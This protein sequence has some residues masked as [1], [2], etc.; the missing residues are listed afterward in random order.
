M[1]R[2]ARWLLALAVCWLLVRSGALAQQGATAEKPQELKSA[3]KSWKLVRN[4]VYAQRPSGELKADLFLQHAAG[5]HP[6][7]VVIHGGAW[8][9]GVKEQLHFVARRLADAG[10]VAMCIQ[11]RL[12][13]KHKFPAQVEDCQEAVTW[14]R[15]HAGKYHVDPNWIAAWGYS[16]GAHLATLLALS[17][18]GD[19]TW[20]QELKGEADTG[21]APAPQTPPSW[22]LQAAVGGGTPVDLRILEPDDRLLV[23]WLG[24]TRGQDPRTYDLAS[25]R[26]WVSAGDPPVFFYHGTVDLLVEVQPVR[27]TVAAMKKLGLK[28]QL[29]ELPKRGHIGA[30]LDPQGVKAGLKFL[31][32]QYQSYRQRTLRGTT[33]S[34]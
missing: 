30:A 7:V 12:A 8:R 3:E 5:S 17:A 20:Q 29:L 31:Q 1:V 9:T 19:R 34:P 27:D 16:A 18:Q 25:P 11:Y 6:A 24:A 32:E 28:A 4:V 14:L 2:I 15:K 13:P 23:F 26:W 22:R 21:P 33:T 10:F